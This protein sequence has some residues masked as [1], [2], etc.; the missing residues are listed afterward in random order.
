MVAL[1]TGSAG[2]IGA[3]SVRFLADK[4]LD[5][6]GLDNDMRAYF[7]GAEASTNWS[8]GQLE[9]QISSYRHEDIDIRDF[10]NDP[11]RYEHVPPSDLDHL[12][13]GQTSRAAIAMSR[14]PPRNLRGLRD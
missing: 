10:E 12:P 9:R 5:V 11:G 13:E 2:L 14:I 8:R 7:F 3:E 6:V 4:G 1:V